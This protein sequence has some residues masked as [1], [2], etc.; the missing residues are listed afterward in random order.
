M[1]L[2]KYL[3]PISLVNLFTFSF[4]G[5]GGGGQQQSAPTSQQTT[6]NPVADWALPT[7]SALIG[8][9]MSNAYNIGPGGEVLGSKGFTPFGG[10]TNAQGNFTGAPISQDQYNQQLGVAGL[11]V[12]GP[13]GL[14]Q[15]SYQAGQNLQM[16]GQFGDASN[17]AQ[18]AGLGGLNAQYNPMSAGYNQIR[19]AQTQAAQMGYAPMSQAAMGYGQ[20]MQAA[21][22][23]G[24]NMQAAQLGNS[25]QA[26]AAAMQAAQ[27][28][29]SPQA[30]AAAMQAAQL[31]NSPQAQA[32]A[33]QAAQL[34]NAP[35]NQAAQFSGPRDVGAQNVGTQ[36]YTGQNVSSY[37]NPYLQGAL[38]PQL[39]EVQRQYDITGTQ[40]RSGA[41]KSGAFGGS[42]EALM[43]AENQRNAGIAKNQII[44]QGYN[45]AFQNAQQ[46]FN[47][48][49]QA[50]LQAQQANQGA[51]LQAGLA[52]QNMGYN[53]G[54]QNA[55]LQQQ[56]NLANQGLMG[57]YGL[58]QGQ[59]GQSANQANQ[60]AQMQANLA[61][62]SLAG[63]YGLQQGQFGQAA[64]QANQ[65][66]QQQTNLANQALAGQ[67]GMQQ[68]QFGQAANQFNAGNQ[69]QANL[70]NQALM[71]Q[72]GL[73]QGQ[74]GQAANAANQQAQNQFGMANL[75][76]QQQANQANQAAQ[77]QFGMANLSNQ[78]QSN[79]ANQGILGQYGMQQGQFNQAANLAN[80]Q[81]RNQAN[82]ANQQAQL[83]AQQQNI[84]QQQFGANYRLQGLQQANQA[85]QTLGGLGTQ[86][87]GAQQGI[88]NNQNTLGTQQQQNQQNLINQA[89]QNYGNQQ[90]YGTT[91]A[92]N[93]MNLLRATPTTSQQ[94]TYQAAPSAISQ[95]GGLGATALGAYGASGGFKAKGGVIK[96]KKMAK[97]GIAKYDVGGSVESSLSDMPNDKLAEIARSSES[98][99][100]REKASEILAER[101]AGTAVSK[102]LG[103][104]GI[105]G[106]G[107]SSM[108]N[109]AGGGIVAFVDGG[110]S[111]EEMRAGSNPNQAEL[112]QFYAGATD[113][114]GNPI[115]APALAGPKADTN[116]LSPYY[117]DY[118]A[119]TGDRKDV[120]ANYLAA[121][122]AA[123]PDAKQQMWGRLME[124]GANTAAGTSANPFTNLAQGA[125]KTVPGFMEDIKDRRKGEIEQ[126][127]AA[128]DISNVEYADK[129][130]LL[131][132]AQTDKN[133][134][135]KIAAEQGISA[136]RLKN[137]LAIAIARDETA[138][139]TSQTSANATVEAA[140]I[141]AESAAADRLSAAGIAQDTKMFS[142]KLDAFK[143]AYNTIV[144]S[145]IDKIG[146]DKMTPADYTDAENIAMR[147]ATTFIGAS[148]KDGNS[149]DG[150]SKPIKL[151]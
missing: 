86:Q 16:P 141:R 21:M 63:Q 41:A 66:T 89:I 17:M 5:G 69:Q 131:T 27:M 31:G 62:Q 35:V 92:T 151:D 57:Q 70:A 81:S 37:M 51:N 125:A 132:L 58:Q 32:A 67:Y 144:K 19:G 102:Q 78:Q 3:N 97:G 99:F 119:L 95:I 61:N 145:K 137:D 138:I 142:A 150:K 45:Q 91:Q 77:N 11:G 60:Q 139:K 80:Q 2:F 130:K 8:S 96:E 18:Q 136:A 109:M 49:Q 87:L 104:A 12:A 56:S 133:A 147:A 28:G 23:S 84:G 83:Q 117:A 116:K 50:S 43:S 122:K 10:A 9:Q 149:K 143:N 129:V 110:L 88:I 22:G 115:A 111:E 118:A 107:S 94:T 100:I 4:G 26:Q 126:A 30:Q 38:D 55:Q 25:P 65:Q 76:N 74:F 14:Q 79:L 48:Q 73:Q 42:R 59:F 134:F 40:Q 146:I 114:E 98:P 46:Q 93:I 113:S 64:N 121:L 140:R 105:T 15:Q 103:S 124:L 44:G 36:D 71:G 85:A 24:Q 106:A 34:N 6:V 135:D 123:Q 75:A 29:N 13:S 68:G 101:N 1:M 90:Q 7:A 82:L 108:A 127:K 33:M 52:N 39:A 72:Y 120:G 47:A 148:T 53:T 128:F 54:L 20:N 112:N